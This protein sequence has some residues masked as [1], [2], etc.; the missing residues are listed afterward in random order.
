MHVD[1]E[2]GILQPK[3][4]IFHRKKVPKRQF[5]A[6]S[7]LSAEA[8]YKPKNRFINTPLERFFIKRFVNRQNIIKPGPITYC[9]RCLAAY[10]AGATP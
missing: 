8:V 6:P 2:K 3:F 5:R 7:G 10:G 4:T 9:D 1:H